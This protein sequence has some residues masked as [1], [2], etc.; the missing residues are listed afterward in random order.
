M[1]QRDSKVMAVLLL[2]FLAGC[3]STFDPSIRPFVGPQKDTTL[4]LSKPVD[5]Q[6]AIYLRVA[7]LPGHPADYS[8]GYLIA[9]SDGDIGRMLANHIEQEKDPDKIA[10]LIRL[11]GDYCALN[12]NCV[13][14]EF[15]GTAATTAVKLLPENY[16][17]FSNQ[18]LDW[19]SKGIAGQMSP[20]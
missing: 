8:L 4:F 10:D 20:P 18:S 17:E 2:C 13:R 1:I 3:K 16:M 19:I 9:T 12:R 6:I 5:E 14:E 11:A 15:V 7:E